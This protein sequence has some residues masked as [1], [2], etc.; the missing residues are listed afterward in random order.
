MKI[1]KKL[2]LA[3]KSPRRYDLL[4][5]YFEDI[6][7]ETNNVVEKYTATLP[8]DIVME[9]A[10]L[11]LLGIKD[12]YY[13]NIVISG[14]T[15]VWYNGRVYGKPKDKE[16][17]VNMLKELSGKCHQVY[18]GF[19]VAY[20]GRVVLG[21][22]VSNIIFKDLTD[23]MIND[24][25]ATGSPLDKAGS[26]GIQDGVVVDSYTGDIS[27]IIGLPLDKIIKVCKELITNE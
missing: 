11:K 23:E 9:L 25:I 14:D 6:Q 13:N 26:Y 18:S 21:Y 5:D 20:Q 19:A 27:T 7:V 1:N 4:K 8:E 12:K 17:A 2:I 24:Y 16:D 10:G 3:S 15:I 22:D